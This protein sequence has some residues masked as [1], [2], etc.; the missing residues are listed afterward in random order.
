MMEG[1]YIYETFGSDSGS[2]D[3]KFTDFLNSKRKDNWKVKDCSYCHDDDN[4][5][6]WASCIFE[7]NP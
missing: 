6:M 3:Q 7:R 2:F 1:E 5:K 4:T